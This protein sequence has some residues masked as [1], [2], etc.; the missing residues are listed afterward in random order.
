MTMRYLVMVVHCSIGFFPSPIGGFFFPLQDRDMQRLEFD[1]GRLVKADLA[2]L[3][4]N[5]REP[6]DR[7]SYASEA[8]SPG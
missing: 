4:L 6:I 7:V 2:N 8:S 1:E 5:L 3:N